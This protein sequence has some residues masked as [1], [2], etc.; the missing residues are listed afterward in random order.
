MGSKQ[1]SSQA[2]QKKETLVGSW[3]G[4]AFGTKDPPDVAPVLGAVAVKTSAEGTSV[5]AVIQSGSIPLTDEAEAQ[6]GAVCAS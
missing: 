2:C 6:I 3:Y 4:I 5:K 1:T